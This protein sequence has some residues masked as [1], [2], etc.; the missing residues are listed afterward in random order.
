M[1]VRRKALHERTVFDGI[2]P[3]E[4]LSWEVVGAWER[5]VAA[6]DDEIAK[7]Q[8]S[9]AAYGRLISEASKLLREAN[10]DRKDGTHG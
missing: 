4:R 10:I 6:I 1:A 5:T 3:D 8:A 2:H 9:R 7:L